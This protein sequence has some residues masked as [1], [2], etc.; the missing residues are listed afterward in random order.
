MTARKPTVEHKPKS[1][2]ARKFRELVG[3]DAAKRLMQSRGGRTMYV[4]TPVRLRFDHELVQLLGWDSAVKFCDEYGGE[5]QL[6]IPTGKTRR[7]KLKR[8]K[9]Q[10]LRSTGESL[11]AVAKAA[12][13]TRTAVKTYLNKLA[14]QRLASPQIDWVTLVEGSSCQTN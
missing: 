10:Q 9:I 1:L 6:Y 12:G 14:E 7:P 4:P 13:C 5:P 2:N 3:K 8:K 11:T